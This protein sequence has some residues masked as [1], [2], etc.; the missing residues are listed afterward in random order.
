MS[1]IDYIDDNGIDM[2]G[3]EMDGVDMD[4]IDM[5]ENGNDIDLAWSNF[6]ENDNVNKYTKKSI[7]DDK[8]EIVS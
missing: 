3:I 1:T 5:D 4:G 8:D 6:C 7:K 2:D